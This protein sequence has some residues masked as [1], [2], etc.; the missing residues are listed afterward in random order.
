[1]KFLTSL[2]VRFAALFLGLAVAGLAG[3]AYVTYFGFDPSTG[4]D[5]TLGQRVD[6]SSNAP[7]IVLSG[8][9]ISAQKGGAND[10]VFVA[11]GTTTGAFVFTFPQA[12]PN[13]F[14]CT[15]LDLTTTTDFV[16]EASYTT[17]TV[18]FAG[19]IV[20]GDLLGYRCGAF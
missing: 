11:T 5:G 12:V 7:V 14:I 4:L 17:K 8:Q 1:M 16:R 15:V 3:A 6:L 13:G 2:K 9:T 18:T 10:G 20:S 19:T